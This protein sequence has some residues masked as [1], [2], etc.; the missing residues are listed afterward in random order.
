M[1]PGLASAADPARVWRDV[2]PAADRLGPV[3]GTPPA[4]AARSGNEI[5][6]Y[7]FSTRDVGDAKGY[8]GKTLDIVVG[9]DM[10]GRITG[11]RLVEQHE[12]IG[13]TGSTV[14][15]LE[16]FVSAYAGRGILEPLS[17]VRHADGPGEVDAISGATV[18]SLVFNQAIL[19]TARA[20]ARSRGLL[21]GAGSVDLAGFE[22][23]DWPALVAAGWIA[24]RSFTV[25]EIEER[26]EERGGELVPPGDADDLFLDVATGL[27]S[28][29]RVGRNILEREDWRRVAA[30][31][32]ARDAVIFVAARGRW[33]VKGTAWR[34]TGVFDRLR[35]IQDDRTFEL[36]AENH[37]PIEELVAQGAP[38]FR[39]LALFVMPEQAGFSADRPW[40]LQVLAEGRGAAGE[41]VDTVLEL[42]YAPPGAKS[43][44]ESGAEPP[45]PLWHEVWR[46]RWLDIAILLTALTVLTGLLFAQDTVV[47]SRV[48]HRRL[49]LGFLVFT[50]V[51]LGWYA[52]AQLSVVNVL[53]FGNA[54]RT[55]FRWDFFLLEPLIFILWSY[56]AA[57]LLFWG[58]GVFCGWLCPFGALQELSNMLAR[59]VGIRQIE[60]PFALHERLRPIKFLIFLGLFALA[61]G[62]M[63]KALVAAEVEP[64]KTAIVLQFWRAWPFVLYAVA[65]L[66]AGLFIQRFFC[67]YMCPLGAALALP[68]RLRQFEWLR[69][70]RQCGQ[71]CQICAVGCP[72]GAIQPRGDIHPGE[73]IYC[74]ACQVNYH[75]DQLCPVM[76]DRRKRREGR[77]AAVEK[78]R[79]ES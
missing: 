15:D 73:C 22:A 74:L 30:E 12:P 44:A 64:F 50:L 13:A 37:L 27:A 53:T 1:L 25:G 69:R 75:D 43:A 19:G 59:R 36:Q 71:P 39:E 26:L 67:R 18:T 5:V 62:S 6:G 61:L 41:T 78:A 65:I 57:A 16:N 63:D 29:A 28:A 3:E 20:V 7:V 2:M 70:H 40:R 35:L 8:S 52:T 58:R 66:T 51:W 72:V 17:V 54:L 48:L 23:M 14:E 79:A 46:Q 77:R 38:E 76:I 11:A 45:V 55:G 42:A 49:R 9:I 34:K 4:A 47:R 68:A 33:S 32:G 31:F 56:V 10:A 60:L 21:G 24:E